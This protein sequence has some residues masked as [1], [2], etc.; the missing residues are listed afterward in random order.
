M[1]FVLPPFVSP[2]AHNTEVKVEAPTAILDHE[3]T[4]QSEVIVK[5]G[6]AE[7][8]KGFVCLVSEATTSAWIPTLGL[9][10]KKQN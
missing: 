5:D 9:L 6:R 4:L 2:D 10:H 8:Y 7:I 1:P 3:A